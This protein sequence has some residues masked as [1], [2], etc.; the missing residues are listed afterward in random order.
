VFAPGSILAGKYRIEQV[1]G[2]G[3]MGMVVAAT[4]I[5]LGTHVALKFLHPHLVGNQG[6][7]ERFMREARASAQLRSE[8]V[9]RVSDVG[10]F[11]DGTAYIVMELLQGTDLARMLRARGTLPPQQA[12]DYLLQACLGIAEAHA[13]RIVHRDLKPANLFVTQRPD[14]TALVKVLDFGV[15]KAPQEGNFSLTQTA[16]VMG[17]PG[18]MSP[19]QLR[20]SKE[21]DARS[22]IWSLGVTLYELLGGRPPWHADSITELTLRIAM[23]PLPPLPPRVP[24][25]LGA[26]LAKS[27]EKDPNGRY[28]NVA[29]FATALAPFGGVNAH[30]LAQG[31]ARV[32]R[33]SNPVIV[34]GN[35]ADAGAATVASPTT[36]GASSGAVMG[37]PRGKSWKVPAIIAV[38][39]VAIGGVGIVAATR[40]GGGSEPA[41]A[42]AAPAPQP[43]PSPQPQLQPQPQPQPPPQPPPQPQPSPQPQ[44]QPPPSPAPAPAVEAAG[45]GS[46][47]PTK[48]TTKKQT[49]KQETKTDIN[50]SRI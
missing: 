15:A 4:H 25:E 5:G 12:V 28:Q 36:L 47:A 41:P 11:E 31:V 23:D 34:G 20:S 22:D 9:C 1:L 16:N 49:H 40:G 48:K 14:G 3:G 42:A 46:A 18:Y 50:D 10:Q 19:E 33:G 29:A 13:M 35:I 8:H 30:E 39:L 27:M 37:A 6:L 44:P 21:A 32:L 24:P 26:V 17:S 38:A 43:Q 2:E 45:S 7:M